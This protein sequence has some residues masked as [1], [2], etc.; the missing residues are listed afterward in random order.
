MPPEWRG[1][2]FELLAITWAHVCAH[3]QCVTICFAASLCTCTHACLSQHAH[4]HWCV[5]LYLSLCARMRSRSNDL[6]IIIQN[7]LHVCGV[8]AP[9]APHPRSPF[10]ERYKSNAWASTIPIDSYYYYYY[11]KRVLMPRLPITHRT[12]ARRHRRQ[13]HHRRRHHHHH[14]GAIISA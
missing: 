7:I 9:F 10:Q 14:R 11:A 2:S 4:P 5:G 6:S 8:P 1:G 13:Q 12:S 3:H